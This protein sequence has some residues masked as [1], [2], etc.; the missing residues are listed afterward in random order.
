[1]NQEP[2]YD[3]SMVMEVAVESGLFSS[4]C[5][6]Q[7]P[8]GVLTDSGSPSGD[9]VDLPG[10]VEV[11][12]MDA[13]L[14]T[15]ERMRADEIKKLSE[16]E[17]LSYRHVLL[18]GYYGLLIPSGDGRPALRAIVTSPS[19][20]VNTYEVMGLEADSQAVMTRLHLRLITI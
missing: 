18:D 11:A 8:D 17:A 7:Q 16:I 6:I 9:W 5:T 20:D 14:A 19:G 4:T 1:M 15:G 3:L 2:L 10:V 13:P 12:C